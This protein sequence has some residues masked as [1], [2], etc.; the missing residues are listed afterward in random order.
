MSCFEFLQSQGSR[1]TT[2]APSAETDREGQ[3]ELPL[4]FQVLPTPLEN[5]CLVLH[6]GNPR[7]PY[8]TTLPCSVISGWLVAR[9]NRPKGNLEVR[10]SSNEGFERLQTALLVDIIEEVPNIR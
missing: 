4:R 7:L 2:Y 10:G 1:A 3:R 6:S 5:S 9:T 8:P